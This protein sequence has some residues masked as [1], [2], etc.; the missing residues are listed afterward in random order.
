M[1]IRGQSAVSHKGDVNPGLRGCEGHNL[2]VIPHSATWAQQQLRV[3]KAALPV[4]WGSL[5][6][7]KLSL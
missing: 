4:S 7:L 6:P 5:W 2:S 1:D 3:P